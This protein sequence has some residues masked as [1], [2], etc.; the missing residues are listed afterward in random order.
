MHPGRALSNKQQKPLLTGRKSSRLRMLP[1]V[2]GYTW[3]VA[4]VA[5]NLRAGSGSVVGST[6]VRRQRG[7]LSHDTRLVVSE[8]IRRRLYRRFNGQSV[9]VCSGLCVPHGGL[10]EYGV[11]SLCEGTAADSDGPWSILS[12]QDSC[13]SGFTRAVG[14]VDVLA[15]FRC[16]C[17]HPC[18][19]E[20]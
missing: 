20:S 2:R 6:V 17:K 7:S 18:S 4:V 13:R 8:A 10:Q 16:V 5:W 15:F 12:E 1:Q 14:A 9:E 11:L 3:A 19:F